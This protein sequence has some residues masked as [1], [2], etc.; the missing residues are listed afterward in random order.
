M[1][2][3]YMVQNAG[4]VIAGADPLFTGQLVQQSSG[5]LL[6]EHDGSAPPLGVV[7]RDCD[8]GG[9]CD[10]LRWGQ[11]QVYLEG[12]G[13][14]GQIVQA[15]ETGTV[16]AEDTPPEDGWTIGVLLVDTDPGLTGICD[17]KIAAAAAGGE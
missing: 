4:P 17:I 13:T 14:A 9:V 11:A 2:G 10:Y 1:A 3:N 6:E 12:G 15:D 5:G 16:T 7:A 8:A